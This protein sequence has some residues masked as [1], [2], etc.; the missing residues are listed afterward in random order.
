VSSWFINEKGRTAQ[1]WPF[2]ALEYW[3]RTHAL[4]PAEYEFL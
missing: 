3:Q 1:N 4:D 2:S